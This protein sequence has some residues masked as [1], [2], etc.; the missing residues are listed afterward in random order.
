[1]ADVKQARVRAGPVVLGHD[2]FGI[3]DRHVV[4][5]E[6]PPCGR[7][8]SQCSACSGVFIRG[9]RG[10]SFKNSDRYALSLSRLRPRCRICLNSRRLLAMLTPSAACLP[11]SSG[12]GAF[13]RCRLPRPFCLSVS[14]AVAPSA[15]EQAPLSPAG[16]YRHVHLTAPPG[17]ADVEAIWR[18]RGGRSM[19][20]C[21]KAGDGLILLRFG[22]QVAVIPPSTTT[23]DPVMKAAAS[24]ARNS[25]A[26]ATSVSPDPTQRVTLRHACF[27]GRNVRAC[28]VGK[29]IDRPIHHGSIDNAGM[30]R[31][32]PHLGVSARRTR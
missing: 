25:T 12:A 22:R 4:T 10:R 26:F 17:G 20:Q 28:R 27:L 6:L 18:K 21:G 2:A 15:V 29:E 7:P 31:T 19:R 24:E 23:S 1:M 14:W 13:Q 32:D 8:A 16:I 30:D 5:A 11:P 3:L 9:S